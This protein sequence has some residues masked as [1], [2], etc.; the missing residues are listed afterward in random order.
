MNKKQDKAKFDKAANELREKIKKN[1][2]KI[3]DA[4]LEFFQRN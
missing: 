3:I 4:Q 2:K 1:F